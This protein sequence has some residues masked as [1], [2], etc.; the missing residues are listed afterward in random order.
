[1]FFYTAYR[2]NDLGSANTQFELINAASAS[3]VKEIIILKYTNCEIN[4]PY[5]PA[6]L[7]PSWWPVD[8]EMDDDNK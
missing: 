1:M 2:I 6:P 4:F 5:T 7:L 8:P 3:F